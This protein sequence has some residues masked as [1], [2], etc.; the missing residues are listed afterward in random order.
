MQAQP[1]PSRRSGPMDRQAFVSK[2]AGS[3]SKVWVLLLCSL[4]GLM[5]WTCMT[6]LSCTVPF[7]ALQRPTLGWM[8]VV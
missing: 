4:D 1:L 3:S 7:A 5:I 8:F 6:M 2:E